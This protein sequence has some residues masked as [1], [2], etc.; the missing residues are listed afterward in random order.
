MQKRHEIW[1]MK[2]E[3]GYFGFHDKACPYISYGPNSWKS[4]ALNKDIS[5]DDAGGIYT[6][7]E[8]FFNS[9][10]KKSHDAAKEHLDFVVNHLL[11]KHKVI[12]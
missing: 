5:R 6:I 8:S 1:Q 2:L 3:E 7:N 9:D 4:I 10:W 12:V 11:S